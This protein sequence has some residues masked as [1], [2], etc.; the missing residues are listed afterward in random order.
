MAM[1]FLP[2]VLW[3]NAI[4]FTLLSSAVVAFIGGLTGSLSVAFIAGYSMFSFI[5]IH[6]EI[7][8]L[9]NMLL[10]TG[11]FIFLAFAFKLWK[12]EGM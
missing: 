2:G 12:T 1:D 9:T 7:A 6:A 5:S 11:T 4:G 8:L 3:Q 10:V